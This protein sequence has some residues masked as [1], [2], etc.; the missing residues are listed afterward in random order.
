M[1]KDGRERSQR[2]ENKQ[3]TGG[4]DLVDSL[5]VGAYAVGQYVGKNKYNK[6]VLF[7]T[8]GTSAASFD[9]DEQLEEI[10][11][12][13]SHNRPAPLFPLIFRRRERER[14]QRVRGPRHR[15]RPPA[16][17][18]DAWLREREA[19]PWLKTKHKG[20]YHLQQIRKY[21]GSVV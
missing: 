15:G 7:I 11:K 8:D 12:Q 3:G 13:V 2:E 19:W 18:R 20:S 10:A 5:C 6:R 9:D 17:D 21:V 1:K 14:P 16:A 4:A